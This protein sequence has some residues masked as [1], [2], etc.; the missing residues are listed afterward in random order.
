MDEGYVE[1]VLRAVEVIPAGRVASYGDL[2]ALLGG[3]GPRRIALVMSHHG[4]AVPWWRVVRNDGSPAP[5][6][7][8]RQLPELEADGVPMVGERVAMAQARLRPAEWAAL[9][10]APQAVHNAFE[11]CRSDRGT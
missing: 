4:A 2:A 7:R 8:S 6:I 9:T 10:P 3:G 11:W 5:Q 1:R